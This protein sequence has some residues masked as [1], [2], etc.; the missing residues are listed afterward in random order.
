MEH[1]VEWSL[2][3]NSDK[4]GKISN[5]Q[6]AYCSTKGTD[7]ALSTLVN[8]I[9]SCILRSKICLVL[10]VDNLATNTI[11]KV[12][13]DN[14]YPPIMIRWYMFL[15][16]WHTLITRSYGTLWAPTS[17]SCRGLVLEWKCITVFHLFI[18][19]SQSSNSLS[20]V[21]HS[22]HGTV[23]GH[24]RLPKRSPPCVRSVSRLSHIVTDNKENV[25]SGH[26]FNFICLYFI[27]FRFNLYV[28]FWNMEQTHPFFSS[29]SIVF[30]SP[31][32]RI[33]DH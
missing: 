10:S 21:R 26:I 2:R 3:E 6:H 27:N 13:V 33:G 24:D 14:K 5:M 20:R 11:H 25:A 19:S 17:S 29:Y 1:V 18:W 8:M 9:E 16:W 22:N 23:S 28:R 32:L 7:T 31:S 12:L 15:L 4:Y 30:H